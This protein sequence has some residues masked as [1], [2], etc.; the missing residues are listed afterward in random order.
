MNL[1]TN[2]NGLPQIMHDAMQNTAYDA[3][4][5]SDYSATT[6]I[7]SPR[8]VQLTKRHKDKI[9]EDILDRWAA[10]RGTAMHSE[11]ERGLKGNP[12]YIVERKYVRFD[13]PE[14]GTEDQFRR[15]A[16][17]LDAY[18]KE[19]KTLF[20][21]KTTTTFIHGKEMKDEW[22]HQLNINAYF[23]EKEGYPVDDICI[24]AIYLDWRKNSARYKDDKYPATPAAEFRTAAWPMEW[25]EK[26]YLDRLGKHVAAETLAD[27]E[28]PECTQEEMWEKPAK[29][30]V[31]KPGADRAT[32]LCDTRE[33]AEAYIANKKLYG[34]KIEHRPG[35]RTM[36]ENYCSCRDFCNQYKKWKESQEGSEEVPF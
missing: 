3:V 26:F 13:K 32:K 20:D 17:K 7:Q 28:L 27:D 29:F 34:Y 21:H 2:N 19:T 23:L 5:G 31:Y 4:G 36:C 14:G 25:R 11:L 18:D 10:F 22:I 24:N 30:A 6:L 9:Q 15:I 12:R 8:K 16:S 33:E 1:L 35:E